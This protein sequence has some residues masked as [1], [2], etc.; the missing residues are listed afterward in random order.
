[1]SR[2]RILICLNI[3][4]LL[5]T[6]SFL[7]YWKWKPIR[8]YSSTFEPVNPLAVAIKG[9]CDVNLRT[10]IYLTAVVALEFYSTKGIDICCKG[11]TP[12]NWYDCRL[13]K[14]SW[15]S[16]PCSEEQLIIITFN[17]TS[18]EFEIDGTQVLDFK[19]GSNDGRCQD[20]MPTS[21]EAS[22]WGSAHL[23]SIQQG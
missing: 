3:L 22:S 7:Q 5:P 4:Q 13:E 19:F 1:M 6:T 20:T 21:I 14:H 16:P 18:L 23:I 9:G 17:N 8:G 10:K 15:T 2:K 12:N 11:S